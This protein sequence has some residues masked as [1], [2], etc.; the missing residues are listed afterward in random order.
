MS[1]PAPSA[2]A[3]T[4]PFW[5]AL[6]SLVVAAWLYTSAAIPA[7]QERA[8]LRTLHA[9]FTALRARYDTAITEVRLGRS[10]GANWDLQSLFVA[11]D[12]HG[13]TPAE[14]A[15]AYPEGA[16]AGVRAPAAKPE[17]PLAKGSSARAKNR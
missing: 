15:A 9:D 6:A 2:R 10:P 5:V 17:R 4:F 13:Y 14:L 1:K 7:V 11:I 8:H 12:Q 3:S 16:V